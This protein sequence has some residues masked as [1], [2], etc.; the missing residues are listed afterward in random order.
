MTSNYP[1]DEFDNPAPDA[2]VGVHRQPKSRWRPVLPFLVVLV[3]VPLLAWGVTYLMLR[4]S[5]DKETPQS[6]TPS[7]S[8]P[9][10][11]T[12]TQPTPSDTPSETPSATPTPDPT[13]TPE[14]EEV[15]VDLATS[16]SVLNASGIQGYAAEV[17]GTISAGGF[18]NV[19]AENTSGWLTQV[20]T[21]FYGSPELEATALQ[22]AELAGISE[23]SLD[24]DSAESSQ[25]VVLLVD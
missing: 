10:S 8:A 19:A 7:T 18:T 12:P 17:A 15:P 6:G 11:Q 2:P 25:V 24:P 5:G 21:V 20:N 9:Q 3:V 23:I 4:T 1:E 16:V 14:E 13:E 22:V